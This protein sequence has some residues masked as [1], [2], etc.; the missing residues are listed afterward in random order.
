MVQ[1][2]ACTAVEYRLGTGAD[3]KRPVQEAERLAHRLAG[4]V[5]AKIE[6]LIFPRSAYYGQARVRL[7][8]VKPKVHMVFIVAQI[9]VEARLVLFDEGIFKNERVFF[10]VGGEKI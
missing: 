8:W 1:T 2:G 6:R 3:G 4:G 9:N 5:R 10:R 7:L